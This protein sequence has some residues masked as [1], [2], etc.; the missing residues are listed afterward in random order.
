MRYRPGTNP[1][2]ISQ[3]P[4]VPESKEEAGDWVREPYDGPS[5]PDGRDATCIWGLGF[6][7]ATP[8]ASVALRFVAFGVHGLTLRVS[9]AG[10]S[11]VGPTRGLEGLWLRGLFGLK[12]Y[13][14]RWAGTGPKTRGKNMCQ[15]QLRLN[16]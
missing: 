11:G 6:G 5:D 13:S 3:L 15:T 16:N 1:A 8:E 9:G 14:L 12:G 10:F 2:W 4:L 7:V